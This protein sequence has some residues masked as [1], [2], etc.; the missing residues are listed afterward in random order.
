MHTNR[1]ACHNHSYRTVIADFI[2][3]VYICL[4]DDYPPPKTNTTNAETELTASHTDVIIFKKRCNI[5][6]LI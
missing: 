4:S 2:Y 5:I 6:M 1:K 3:Y